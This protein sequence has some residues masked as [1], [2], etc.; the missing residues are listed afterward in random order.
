[1]GH[2]TSEMRR[3]RVERERL[4]TVGATARAARGI[5]ASGGFEG[6]ELV[7][8]IRAEIAAVKTEI[9]RLAALPVPSA[10]VAAR[11]DRHV[12]ALAATWDP[13]VD[14]LFGVDPPAP[15]DVDIAPAGQEVAFLCAVAPDAVK[16]LLRAKTSARFGSGEAMSTTERNARTAALAA[17]LRALEVREELALR[18]AATVG[19][20]VAGRPDADPSIGIAATGALEAKIGAG[21]PR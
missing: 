7:P 21:V 1:M 16:A 18:A 4:E 17:R 11:I 10:E 20:A 5:V 15:G 9:D 6:A 8:V 3:L 13:D 2:E 12:A 19:L 14:A